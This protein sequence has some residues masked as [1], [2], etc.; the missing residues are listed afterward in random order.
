MVKPARAGVADEERIRSG[1]GRVQAPHQGRERSGRFLRVSCAS[2][3]RKQNLRE[4]PLPVLIQACIAVIDSSITRATPAGLL[5]RRG[6]GENRRQLLE[7]CRDA[8]RERRDVRLHCGGCHLVHFGEDEDERDGI[9]GEPFDEFQINCPAVSSPES[10]SAKTMQRFVRCLRVMR[11]RVIEPTRCP[12][13]R[14][15]RSRS[16]A[17]PPG[18]NTCSS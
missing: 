9:A 2:D 17:D 11:H 4:K 15:R 7:P 3:G 6:T 10:I 16:P 14:L 18:A 1:V 12:S 13:A 8:G 5:R